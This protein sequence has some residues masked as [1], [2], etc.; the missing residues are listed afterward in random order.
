MCRNHIHLICSRSHLTRLQQ[1]WFYLLGLYMAWTFLQSKWGCT[2][3]VSPALVRA[4]HE[5]HWAFQQG[6]NREGS[7]DTADGPAW[8]RALKVTGEKAAFLCT[9]SQWLGK[10]FRKSKSS[11]FKPISVCRLSAHYSFLPWISILCFRRRI[12]FSKICTSA[13]SP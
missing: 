5:E 9:L 2:H 13:S 10:F 3:Q 6:L 8:W 12:W 1:P 4:S 11:Y 7:G